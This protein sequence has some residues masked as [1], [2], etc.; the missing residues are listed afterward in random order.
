MTAALSKVKVFKSA[1]LNPI[2]MPNT[3]TLELGR[4]GIRALQHTR[5]NA[6]CL[7]QLRR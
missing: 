1:S 2:P 3:T 4:Y 6:T 7:E 5:V